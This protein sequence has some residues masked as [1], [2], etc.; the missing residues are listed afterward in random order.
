MYQEHFKLKLQPFSEHAAVNS[1]WIDQRMKE[2]LARLTFLVN[3]AALGLVTGG[4]R[5]QHG[6]RRGQV[7]VVEVLSRQTSAALRGRLL[8]P[9]AS[10]VLRPLEGAGGTDG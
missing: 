2:A 5:A 3:H 9:H 10:S 8:P 7:G 1:L 6:R 4:H